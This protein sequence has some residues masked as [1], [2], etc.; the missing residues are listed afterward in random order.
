MVNG[1]K[2]N[3]VNMSVKHYLKIMR[4]WNNLNKD[5][6]TRNITLE[7]EL[8]GSSPKV[9]EEFANGLIDRFTMEEK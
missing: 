5:L 3:T 7:Q 8:L 2:L 9:Q 4:A 6:I 1:E